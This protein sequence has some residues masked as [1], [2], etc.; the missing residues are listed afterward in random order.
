MA[1]SWDKYYL[2]ETVIT[3]AAARGQEAYYAR[4]G[5]ELPDNLDLNREFL[6][7][8][9]AME[10]TGEC[11]FVTGKA[12]TG[13]ST[14]LKYFK[15]HTSKNAVILAPTGV[16]AVNVGGQTIHS[17]FKF[18]PRLIQ[19]GTIRKKRNRKLIRELDTVII[20]EVSMVR[21][22]LMDGIDYALRVNRD[23]MDVPFGGVQV[24]F[25]GDLFQLPP[26]VEPQAAEI[27]EREYDSPYFFQARAFRKIKPRCIELNKVYRQADV[28]FLNI[29]NRIRD[30][31]HDEDDLAALN[32]RAAVKAASGDARCI[33]LTSTNRQ[34]GVINDRRLAWL[35]GKTYMFQCA[36][37][38]DFDERQFPTEPLLKLKPGAQVIMLRNDPDKRWVNG[39]IAEVAELSQESV[40]VRI[41]GQS[42]EL[43]R[44]KWEKIEYE[45]N[46]A[47]DKI[48]ERVTGTFEQFPL[49]LAWAITI[50]KSQGQT[51]DNVVIDLGYGAFTHGQVYVG[52]SRCTSLEGIILKQP[53]YD[54]DIIFDERIYEFRQRFCY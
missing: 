28:R 53:I 25:F 10:H 18:P 48:E 33:V 2:P 13:K 8:F 9:E 32:S 14:L 21:A 15:A 45:Y 16:A 41:E 52:L 12:G 47:K 30:R 43:S 54:R 4:A 3:D 35:P 46:A 44:M 51:F 29:L 49:K 27:L 37:N 31:R 39:T 22:D 17:F 24:I 1:L 26:V 50:H 11:I 19:P 42:H 40:S 7:A 5:S 6:G 20:D 23:A 36:L 34:A 38:K